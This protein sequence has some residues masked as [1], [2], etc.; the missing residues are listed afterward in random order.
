MDASPSKS[1]TNLIGYSAI[2]YWISYTS[3]LE[4]NDFLFFVVF[5]FVCSELIK[6]LT[7][8]TDLKFG[9]RVEDVVARNKF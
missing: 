5:L 1:H 4:L 8:A 3:I 2:I 6:E 7:R 9:M